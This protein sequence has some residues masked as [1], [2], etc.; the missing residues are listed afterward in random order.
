MQQK[1]K[2]NYLMTNQTKTDHFF[3]I[4]T[5]INNFFLQKYKVNHVI[6]D[7]MLYL[8]NGKISHL[9]FE[10]KKTLHNFSNTRI[11]KRV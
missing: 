2:R 10:K 3:F 4:I 6:F 11:R 5:V 9:S 7:I 8:S 1:Q